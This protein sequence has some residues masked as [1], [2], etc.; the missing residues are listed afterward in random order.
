MGWWR[1]RI[2]GLGDVDWRRC[3]DCLYEG[4]YSGA[5]SVEHEHPVW[6]GTPEK[7]ETGLEIARRTCGR[8]WWDETRD[9]RAR[10]DP[11]RRR[12]A[13]PGV[14]GGREASGGL[15]R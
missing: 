2:P 14:L 10:R 8:C 9:A 13:A 15:G 3:L 11:R 7:V 6:S 12:A 5:L 1:Y 4:G